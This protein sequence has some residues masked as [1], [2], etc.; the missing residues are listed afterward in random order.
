[1]TQAIRTFSTVDDAGHINLPAMPQAI[2]RK[3]EVIILVEDSPLQDPKYPLRGT[4]YR[5]DDPFTP[6]IPPEEWESK[7]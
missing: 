1:M 3:V 5:F 2:G 4:A 6:P 7:E